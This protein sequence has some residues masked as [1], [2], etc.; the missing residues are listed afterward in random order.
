MW[1]CSLIPSELEPP[2]PKPKTSARTAQ[3]LI[4]QGIG[5]KFATDFGS[6]ELRKQENARKSRI[7]A[8]QNMKDDAWGSD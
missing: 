8:R 1:Q 4:A 2:I 3:R 6:N 5:I 7:L